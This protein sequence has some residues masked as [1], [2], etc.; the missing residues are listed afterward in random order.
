PFNVAHLGTSAYGLWVLT[1]SIT[2]YF[3]VLDLGY[4]GALVKFV[5]QYRARRDYRALNE[6]LSTI[7]VVFAG[8]GLVTYIVAIAIGAY[9]GRLFSLSPDQAHVGRIV[10]LIISLNVACGTAFSVFGGVINGFQR[11]DLNNIVGTVSSVVI[12]VVNVAVLA[13]GFGL[14]E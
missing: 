12:A 8:F 3:S 10:L 13:A 1:G 5:A 4:G 11:Y 2:A 14:V 7:F 6:I 9:L